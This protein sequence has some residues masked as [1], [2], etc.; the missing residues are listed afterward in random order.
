MEVR[1]LFCIAITQL[2]KTANQSR[3]DF[4]LVARRKNI[5]SIRK[6]THRKNDITLLSWYQH[7]DRPR[8]LTMQYLELW[9]NIAKLQKEGNL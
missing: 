7:L 2:D 1:E 3:G 4:E 5:Y 8:F 6:E 9:Q